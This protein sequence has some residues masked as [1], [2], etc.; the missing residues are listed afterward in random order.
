MT[1]H[2][3]LTGGPADGTTAE[4]THPIPEIRVPTR[5]QPPVPFVAYPLVAVPEPVTGPTLVY[6]NTGIIRAG[7]LIYRYA[8][9]IP[10]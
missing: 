5:I 1:W 9:E 2:I 6:R 10:A 8:E 4:V 3:E 7:V